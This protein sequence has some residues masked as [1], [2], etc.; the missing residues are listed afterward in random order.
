MANR[1]STCAAALPIAARGCGVTRF[2]RGLR[3]VLIDTGV[4]TVGDQPVSQGEDAVHVC[5]AAGLECNFE[6]PED[7][8]VFP[9][10]PAGIVMPL[11]PRSAASDRRA[12]RSAPD[13]NS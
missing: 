1:R 6:T 8:G 13:G 7:R 11:T 2:C 9:A 5:L 12:R 4:D 3:P 10:E